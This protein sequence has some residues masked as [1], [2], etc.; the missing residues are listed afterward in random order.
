[1]GL[2]ENNGTFQMN[3]RHGRHNDNEGDCHYWC[4]PISVMKL[5]HQQLRCL[6]FFHLMYHCKNH[7]NH[8]SIGK[9]LL[10]LEKD[11]LNRSNDER[12]RLGERKGELARKCQQ[13]WWLWPVND[14]MDDF[15]PKK[16]ELSVEVL[17]F[18]D[19]VR[20]KI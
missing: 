1:M 3:R 8:L 13:M 12:V 14:S 6:V 19:E 4:G 18:S 15:W 16:I 10:I 9:K 5:T 20:K 17:L 7:S 11:L 2:G